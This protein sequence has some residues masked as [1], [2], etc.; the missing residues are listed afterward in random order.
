MALRTGVPVGGG[1]CSAPH[2][3]RLHRS[4]LAAPRRFMA[5]ASVSCASLLMERRTWRSHQTAS[6]GSTRLHLF[7]RHRV[8]RLEGKEPRSV[9]SERVR[10]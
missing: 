9:H 5:M 7:Q 10:R 4:L 3:P 2:P 1:V 8:A 6:R